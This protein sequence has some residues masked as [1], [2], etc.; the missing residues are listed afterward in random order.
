M[1][2]AP[3]KPGTIRKAEQVPHAQLLV[4]SPPLRKYH[5]S[6]R[7]DCRG[8]RDSQDRR[9]GIHDWYRSSPT[10]LLLVVLPLEALH[11]LRVSWTGVFGRAARVRPI[12]PHRRTVHEEH[13]DDPW[14]QNE[15]DIEE[16][17]NE[18]VFMSSQQ[19]C[20]PRPK[21]LMVVG[22]A[23]VDVYSLAMAIATMMGIAPLYVDFKAG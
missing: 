4:W 15:R 6:L 3:V 12:R 22:V 9:E 11:H 7:K 5:R 21:W 20:C 17:Q 19:R 2:H 16:Q 8:D 13:S 14:Y 23:H 1:E 10:S 18:G